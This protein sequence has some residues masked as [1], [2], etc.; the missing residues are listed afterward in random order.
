MEELIKRVR[1]FVEDGSISYEDAAETL[2]EEFDAEEI[3][4]YLFQILGKKED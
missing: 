1:E 2:C 4:V 3:A